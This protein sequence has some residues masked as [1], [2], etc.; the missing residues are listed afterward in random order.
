MIFKRA[1][2]LKA[3]KEKKKLLSLFRS[4]FSSL[5]LSKMGG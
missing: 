1:G 3:E 5:L 4:P 2:L